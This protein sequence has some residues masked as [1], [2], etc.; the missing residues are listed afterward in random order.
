MPGASQVL[1]HSP[2]LS[3]VSRA[4]QRPLQSTLPA[5]SHWHSPFV[6]VAPSA[7]VTPHPPQLC[8]SVLVSTQL[9]WQTLS[10]AFGQT[11]W[12]PW[13]LTGPRQVLPQAPQLSLSVCSAMQ[14]VPQQPSPVAQPAPVPHMQLPLVLQVSSAGQPGAVPHWHTPPAAVSTHVSFE[15]QPLLAMTP[16]PSV[17]AS[18]SFTGAPGTP[19]HIVGVHVLLAQCSVSAHALPHAPQF[20]RSVRVSMQ[21]PAQQA[22]F[23]QVV[24]APQLMPPSAA[25]VPAVPVAPPAPLRP[26]LPELTPAPPLPLLPPAPRLVPLTPLMPPVPPMSN[27]FMKGLT[28]LAPLQPVTVIVLKAIAHAKALAAIICFDIS[29]SVPPPRDASDR[30]VSR[31]ITTDEL[32]CIQRAQS[33]FLPAARHARSSRGRKRYSSPEPRVKVQFLR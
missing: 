15:G 10:P 9:F 17:P 13:Q 20:L 12:P 7:Q 21:I 25:E 28:V 2:Q 6:Q 16:V 23:A 3:L 24:V 33:G 1:P 27:G 31:R 29:C 18:L 26:A 8:S 11:H 5:T 4:T 22:P 30:A 32:R 19:L 14:L